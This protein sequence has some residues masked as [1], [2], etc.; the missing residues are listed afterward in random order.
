MNDRECDALRQGRRALAATLACWLVA[1]RGPSPNQAVPLPSAPPRRDRP[2]PAGREPVGR[3]LEHHRHLRG[4]RRRSATARRQAA[5]SARPQAARRTRRRHRPVHRRPGRRSASARRRCCCWPSTRATGRCT[6]PDS[7]AASCAADAAA[8]AMVEA[9]PLAADPPPYVAVPAERRA[10]QRWRRPSRFLPTD[11]GYPARWHEV[12]DDGVVF[13]DHPSALPG[14]LDRLDGQRHGG[15][16]PV[17][18]L[19]D[20]AR[21]ARRRRQRC[22]RRTARRRSPATGGSPCPTTTPCAAVADGEA[23]NWVIGGGY[24]TTGDLRTVNGTT[25]QKFIQ[26]FVVLNNAGPQSGSAGCFQDAITHGLGHA[27]GLGHSDSGGAMMNPLPSGSCASGPRGLGADDRQPASPPSTRASPAGPFPPARADGPHR[28][29]RA[30]DG[31]PCRGRRRPRAARPS[32]TSST[33]APRSG[34]YNLGSSVLNCAGD[35]RRL[36]RR[37][38]RHLLRPGAGAERGRH[39]RPSPEAQVDGRRLLAAGPAGHAESRRPTTPPSNLQ[40]SAA[41]VRGDAGL[42]LHRRQRA[43]P[44]QPAGAG[45]SRRA[46][47]RSPPPACRTAPTTRGWQPPTSAASVRPP[48]R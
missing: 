28:L 37:A 18:Q 11:G 47:P 19:R 14:T 44:R 23:D 6:P 43:R 17:A 13:V 48:T 15:H 34:V 4:H 32:A 1:L 42:S 38:R 22:R 31:E 8:I 45:L 9:A 7:A 30:V 24:Y 20:G 26:G 46:S 3:P 25:F 29:G 12:D 16:Q 5:R 21:P 40:W 33:P 35:Q 41:T 10:I 27:L 36:R 2:G 39:Q